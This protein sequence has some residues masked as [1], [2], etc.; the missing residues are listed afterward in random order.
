MRSLRRTGFTLIELLVVIAIIAILIGLLLPAVQ[1][2]REAAARMEC[3]NHL[4]QFGLAFHNYHNTHKKFP[5]S[6]EHISPKGG[7]AQCFHSTLTMIL[8]YIE[9]GNVYNQ[10]NLKE[11]HNEGANAALVANGQG[12][13][14]VI[15]T[16]LCPSNPIRSKETDSQ[17]YGYSD[18]AA[19]P[20]VKK[21]N[22]NLYPSALTSSAYPANYYQDYTGGADVSPSKSHQLKPSSVIGAIINLKQ[23]ASTLSTVKDGTSNSILVYED[24][25][26]DEWMDGFGSGNYCDPVT[27]KGRAHWR[28]GEPD[29]TSGCSKEINNNKNAPDCPGSTC[30]WRNHDTGANNEWFSFH[31]GGANAVMADG[32]VRFFAEDIPV[33]T[34]F[35]LGTRA[36]GEVFSV[37]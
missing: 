29:N 24:V 36:G 16:Y 37:D 32:S 19:L 5:R 34:V 1:K 28:W 13:G 6:G 3:K 33:D 31:D 22:G 7:T 12:F 14:A 4:K 21:T 20:Y 2:V 15:K 25:G 27:L 8:A 11:R 23:G 17:G 35:A 10:L 26:R 9:Q 30:S 18:Y